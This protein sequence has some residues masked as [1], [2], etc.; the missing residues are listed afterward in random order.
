VTRIAAIDTV[1]FRLPLRGRLQWGRQ[2][3]LEV[4]DAVLVRVHAESGARGVAEAPPRPTI[5]GETRAS[6]EAA[7]RDLLAPR[8]VGQPLED[9]AG[10][11]RAMAALAGNQTAKGALDMALHDALARERGVTLPALLGAEAR[12]VEVSYILG[13]GP[14]D[15]AV[16][17][18]RWVVDRGV[19]VLKV[20]IGGD[21]ASDLERIAALRSELGPGVRLYADA[22]ETLVPDGAAASLERL[23]A[24]GVLWCEEPLPV[25]KLRA[26]AELRRRRVLPL[27]ADD[28]AFS[29]RDLERE[30]EADTFDVINLK[31][32]RTGFQESRDMLELARSRGKGAMV[33]SQASTTIGT[34]RA[35]A[36]AGL[37]GVDHPCEL[38]FFLKLDAEI[39]DRPL[40]IRDGRLDLARAAEVE[41]DVALLR[42]FTV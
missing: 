40:E 26:R 19:R 23:A 28:S 38:A 24:A 2:S 9:L 4:A 36:F 42:R 18:A 7:V 37:A 1:A 41:I 8:L 20:K 31:P 33:G 22:N 15:A 3:V 17:E 30:L 6:I 13:L 14:L 5:Y 21:L 27:I 32:A 25:Q 11:R 39:V 29:L 12:E 34:A 35:A 16:G 10:A